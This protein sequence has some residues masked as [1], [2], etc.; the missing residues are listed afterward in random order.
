MSANHALAAPELQASVENSSSRSPTSE[1]D[2]ERLLAQLRLVVGSGQPLYAQLLQQLESMI[3]TG[4]LAPGTL[5]PSERELCERIGVSRIT[6]KRAYAE[7]HQRQLISRHQGLGTLVQNPNR[8][9][10]G[11]DRLK[12]F[13]EE[14]RLLG[15]RASSRILERKVLRG[16]TPIRTRTSANKGVS[17]C[18]LRVPR[19]HRA[20]AACA[21]RPASWC[22]PTALRLIS[23]ETAEGGRS[24]PRAIAR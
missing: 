14:M 3:V 16:S 6:V 10:P 8:L 5:L 17:T 2:N 11:M 4:E 13:T 18:S 19:R 15:L 20:R 12:D 21:A 23:R 24:S 7:L 9:D 22:L 1:S